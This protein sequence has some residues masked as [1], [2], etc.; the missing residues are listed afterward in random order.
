MSSPVEKGAGAKPY[1]HAYTQ[2]S[3]NDGT[4]HKSYRGVLADLYAAVGRE[5][6]NCRSLRPRCRPQA[7]HLSTQHSRSASQLIPTRES[8]KSKK[9]RTTGL[10]P[11]S[12]RA[13]IRS[14]RS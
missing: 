1:A 10:I 12:V 5:R 11:G 13:C 3:F 6:F 4:T 14:F 9:N 2:P 8:F 7:I